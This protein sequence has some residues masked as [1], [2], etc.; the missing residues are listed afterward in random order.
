M[1]CIFYTEQIFRLNTCLGGHSRGRRGGGG[2]VNSRVDPST[3]FSIN[4]P[5]S[6]RNS[7]HK[8]NTNQESVGARTF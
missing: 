2:W 5:E 4:V 7:E 3:V 6:L 8:P 1:K